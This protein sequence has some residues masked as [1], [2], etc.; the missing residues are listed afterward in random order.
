MRL[1]FFNSAVLANSKMD[2][3]REIP[4][5]LNPYNIFP[6]REPSGM[7]VQIMQ[8]NLAGISEKLGYL[9]VPVK[10]RLRPK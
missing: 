10:N 4:S 5:I 3:S 8:K 9:W 2:Y 1:H 6:C 7:L